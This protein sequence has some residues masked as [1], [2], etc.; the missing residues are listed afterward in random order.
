M[1]DRDK[2]ANDVIR[3]KKNRPKKHFPLAFGFC[4]CK[5]FASF[6]L[7]AAEIA[8]FGLIIDVSAWVRCVKCQN[9]YR[10]FCGSIGVIPVDHGELRRGCGTNDTQSILVDSIYFIFSFHNFSFFIVREREWDD[11][12]FEHLDLSPSLSGRL[13]AKQ[14][15]EYNGSA[16][17]RLKLIV[18]PS[19]SHSD[20]LLFNSYNLL[21]LT[22][23]L[24]AVWRERWLL[25]SRTFSSTRR[26]VA[27]FEIDEHHQK[28]FSIEI[29]S[30]G[31]DVDRVGIYWWCCFSSVA[32]S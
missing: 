10:L 21:L 12:T 28:S 24:L 27:Y 3:I 30:T 29:C 14:N 32:I 18:L 4:V 11:G 16:K 17:R 8:S 15:M 19:S 6:E 25:F 5:K 7:E 31:D 23:M 22:T 2:L 20:L 9:T 26:D 1:L 13:D